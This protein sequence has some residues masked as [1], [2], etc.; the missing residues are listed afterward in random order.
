M[1]L[2]AV[3]IL[4]AAPLLVIGDLAANIPLLTNLRLVSVLSSVPSEVLDVVGVF[5]TRFIVLVVERAIYCLVLMNKKFGIFAQQMQ[6]LD[7]KLVY[8]VGEAA[9]VPIAAVLH[10][11]GVV[12]AQ[13]CLIFLGVVELLNCI[14]GIRALEALGALSSGVV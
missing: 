5:A 8:I 3:H 14:M 7:F 1:A 4:G 6:L 11:L 13:F 2:L 9:V 10:L 12:C